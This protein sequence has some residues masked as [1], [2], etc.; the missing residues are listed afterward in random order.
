MTDPGQEGEALRLSPTMPA[1][2][3]A[4]AAERRLQQAQRLWPPLQS[5][6]DEAWAEF[7]DFMGGPEPMG[8]ERP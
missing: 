7:E 4:L 1:V 3:Q 5:E 8:N 6:P 2:Q